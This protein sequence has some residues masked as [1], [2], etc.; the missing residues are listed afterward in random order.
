MLEFLA[1]HDQAE[2]IFHLARRS[3]PL[4]VRIKVIQPQIEPDEQIAHERP[5]AVVACAG[6]QIDRPDLLRLH[7]TSSFYG[8]LMVIAGVMVTSITPP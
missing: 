8:V 2:H 4:V 6:R 3:Q 7:R 5:L 1:R